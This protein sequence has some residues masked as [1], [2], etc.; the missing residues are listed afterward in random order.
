MHIFLS[1]LC[2]HLFSNLSLNTKIT[3]KDLNVVFGDLNTDNQDLN[4]CKISDKNPLCVLIG[5]E[6]DFTELERKKIVGLGNLQCFKISRNILRSET[7][8]IATLSIISYLIN[9]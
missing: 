8:A 6:G 2:I 1:S 4:R 3:N 7:A 5:P 9:S